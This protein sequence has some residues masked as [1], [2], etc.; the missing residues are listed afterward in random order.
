VRGGLRAIG[1]TIGTRGFHGGCKVFPVQ[2]GV[3]AVVAGEEHF[4]S[5]VPL[6]PWRRGAGICVSP[7]S[8]GIVGIT[9]IGG[10]KIETA[11]QLITEIKRRKVGTKVSIEFVRDKKKQSVSVT[12]DDKPSN[13]QD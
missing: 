9:R 13:I 6:I 3:E 1:D 8:P 10:T 11:E 2:V 7:P 12:L 4:R 5:N